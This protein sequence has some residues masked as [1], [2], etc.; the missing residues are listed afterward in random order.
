MRTNVAA[1]TLNLCLCVLSSAHEFSRLPSALTSS[2]AAA[3]AAAAQPATPK[4]L[5]GG[6]KVKVKFAVAVVVAKAAAAAK[7]EPPVREPPQQHLS[8]ASIAGA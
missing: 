5:L 7:C 3:A 1:V 2:T 4:A 8:G 6:T